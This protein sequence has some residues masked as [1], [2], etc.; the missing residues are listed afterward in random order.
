MEPIEDL[1]SSGGVGTA[2][3][4]GPASIEPQTNPRP[5]YEKAMKRSV[6]STAWPLI[7]AIVVVSSCRGEG[8]RSVIDCI[9][10]GPGRKSP[11]AQAFADRSGLA[12]LPLGSAQ[13]GDERC[14]E[15]G[16]S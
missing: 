12:V 4:L 11:T 1:G 13:T 15:L 3:A 2:D 5:G 6:R 8:S 7:A 9:F 10:L 14:L 16:H